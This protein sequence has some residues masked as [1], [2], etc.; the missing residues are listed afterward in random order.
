MNGGA[1]EEGKQKPFKF[2]KRGA[3]NPQIKGGLY[4]YCD[5]TFNFV[6]NAAQKT[7]AYESF[8]DQIT[9]Y[10]PKHIAW[11]DCYSASAG[12]AAGIHNERAEFIHKVIKAS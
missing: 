4:K 5:K 3:E 1:Q 6:R 7:N 8:N 10:A 11:G 9:V 12:I 2:W